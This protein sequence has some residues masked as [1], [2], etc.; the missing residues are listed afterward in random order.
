MNNPAPRR[1]N[2]WNL[3][4]QQAAWDRHAANRAFQ[5]RRANRHFARAQFGI[6]FEGA[7]PHLH[8][9][10]D[11]LL[12]DMDLEDILIDATNIQPDALRFLIPV[13]P[14]NFFE[15]FISSTKAD[16]FKP[17]TFQPPAFKPPGFQGKN[18]FAQVTDM[19]K[20]R[21]FFD[22][23]PVT[24]ANFAGAPALVTPISLA[25]EDPP[26]SLEVLSASELS[27]PESPPPVCFGNFATA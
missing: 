13:T 8:P 19:N 7:L 2:P 12:D 11:A 25:V 22:G 5:Q 4:Q 14:L 24:P 23:L 10:D 17:F 15:A 16:G 26:V 27:S 9:V 20:N 1:A 6:D 3:F 21:N 18:I